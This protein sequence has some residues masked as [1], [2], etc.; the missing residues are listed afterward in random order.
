LENDSPYVRFRKM[1]MFASLQ[2]LLHSNYH[3]MA[4]AKPHWMTASQSLGII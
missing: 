3:V 1:I 4:L 2:Q